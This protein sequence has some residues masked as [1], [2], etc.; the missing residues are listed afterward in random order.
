MHN[1]E[2]L[3]RMGLSY[4][5]IQDILNQDIL[6]QDIGKD[7]MYVPPYPRND[8]K[9]PFVPKVVSNDN[10]V[11]TDDDVTTIEQIREYN[12]GSIVRLPD[13]ADGQP[14]IAR[15]KRPSLLVLVKSGKIPNSL[16]NQATE[17]F[18]DGAG[19]LGSENTI[20]DLYDI[21]ETICESALVKPSY[22][23][24]KDNGLTLNDQQMMA[25]FSYTQQGVRALES[26]R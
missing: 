19:S 25:I 2:E 12:K 8:G 24:L 26:F 4:E 15:V 16:L 20:S 22:R 10:K 17:L 6:N 7:D 9:V 11:L 13:F 1:V 3:K 5:Q 23:E 14:F 21:M 18:K